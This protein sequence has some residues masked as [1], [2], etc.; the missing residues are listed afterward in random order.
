MVYKIAKLPPIP[1]ARS[2][3]APVG[4]PDTNCELSRYT[5]MK[6]G[7]QAGRGNTQNREPH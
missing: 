5:G 1:A 4:L 2:D 7:L 3:N 6:C